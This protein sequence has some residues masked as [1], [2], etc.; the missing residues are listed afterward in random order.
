MLKHLRFKKYEVLILQ[1]SLYKQNYILVS[2]SDCVL[3]IG[4]IYYIDLTSAKTFTICMKETM[5]AFIN[6]LPISISPQPLTSV[7][8]SCHMQD[9][10]IAH[11]W[12]HMIFNANP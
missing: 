1:F 10:W 9:T 3:L 12:E 6:S 7:Y 4:I 11:G 5:Q 8:D 2:I